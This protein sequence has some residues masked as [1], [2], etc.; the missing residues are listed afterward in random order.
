MISKC[1]PKE[2]LK[3]V[4]KPDMPHNESAWAAEFKGFLRIFLNN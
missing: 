3:L 2:Q 4:I 1:Y